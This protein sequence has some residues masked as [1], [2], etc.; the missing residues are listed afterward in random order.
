ME[1]LSS[2]CPSLVIIALPILTTQRWAAPNCSRVLLNIAHLASSTSVASCSA[3]TA[4]RPLPFLQ[5]LHHRPRQGFGALAGQRGNGEP[6]A[7]S[8]RSARRISNQR[9]AFLLPATSP[10][11]SAPASAP[12]GQFR[13]C[14]AVRQNDP[15][16]PHRIAAVAV[17][18]DIHQMQQQPGAG[19]MPQKLNAQPRPFRR[20]LD[21]PGMS[22]ITKLF[23]GPTRTTPRLGCRVVKG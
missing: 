23:S 4:F 20:A 9:L 2:P 5:P 3:A 19:E 14:S 12:G 18:R 8:S 13:R 1:K 10:A 15:R 22:A 16:I 11:C 17:G 7:R 6:R 21:Q